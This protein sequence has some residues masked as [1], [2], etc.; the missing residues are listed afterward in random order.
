M[1]DVQF[2]YRLKPIAI[3]FTDQREVEKYNS[4]LL[5]MSC[6]DEQFDKLEVA[7]RDQTKE[8]ADIIVTVIPAI[9]GVMELSVY[10]QIRR[11]LFSREIKYNDFF[12]TIER[13]VGD[14][15]YLYWYDTEDIQEVKQMFADM[16][17]NKQIP[18]L[19]KWD[20]SCP[21]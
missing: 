10:H 4:V 15:T 5:S 17:E 13:L 6:L 18:D 14:S 9:D 1:D 7:Y 16:I 21:W 11:R 19:T 2:Y 8:R 12:L 20:S 3:D